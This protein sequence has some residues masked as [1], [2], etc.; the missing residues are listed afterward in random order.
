MRVRDIN[1]SDIL[2]DKKSYK[3]TKKNL[4]YDILYKTFIGAKPLRIRFDEIE[5][6]VKIY[7]G[8]R[9]LVLFGNAWCDEICDRI[10]YII[11]E[12]TGI[13]DSINWYFRP[14]LVH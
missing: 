13:T 9:Y 4:I 5:K 2:L 1:F 6:S 3:N 8:S 14:K 7:D 11:S 10:G 12:K